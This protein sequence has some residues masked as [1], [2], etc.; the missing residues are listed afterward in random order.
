MGPVTMDEMDH[1]HIQQQIY[2]N[3]SNQKKDMMIVER[4]GSSQ[5]SNKHNLTRNMSA[6][7]E[8]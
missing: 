6:L 7:E 8:Q 1:E 4:T 5:M 3:S 2:F